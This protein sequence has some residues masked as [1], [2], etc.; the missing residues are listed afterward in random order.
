VEPFA[1]AVAAVF[2][3]MAGCSAIVG[4]VRRE[5]R[6]RTVG[7]VS[8]VLRLKS[9]GEAA[10]VLSCPRPTARALAE[11]VLAGVSEPLD[12][13][14]IADCVGELANVIAGQ[15][16]ALLAGTPNHFTFSPPT[17]VAGAAQEVG[18]KDDEGS[19]VILFG[20]EL[21]EFALQLCASL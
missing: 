21:G 13:G 19:V 6:C 18:V 12:E 3:E 5:A 11:R 15:A 7:E 4:S 9:A 16:K 17:V 20:S 2:A 14:M 1:A 8:A 10:L